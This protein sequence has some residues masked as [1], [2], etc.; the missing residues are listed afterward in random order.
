[1]TN[2]TSNRVVS[3][4]CG[5]CHNS[6]LMNVEVRD[7]RVIRASGVLGDPRTGG[8]LCAKGL[9]APQIAH[10]PRRILH[11]H[12]RS[13][14]RGS[15]KFEQVSWDTALSELAEKMLAAKASDGPQSVAF[16]RG[17]AAGWGF[18]YDMI[19]RLAHAFG[20]EVG[21]GASE[22]FVPRAV[23]EVLT[24]GG[25]PLLHDYDHTDLM[26]FWGRQPA[27]SGAPSLRKI[28]DARDRG[29][30]LVVVDPVRFH[31]AARA[32]Q[33][34]QV[35]P[36]TDLAMMLAMLYEIIEKGL[37]NQK[38]VDNYTNDPGLV[39]LRAH[40]H[41]KNRLGTA[42]TPEWAEGI[43]SVEAATIRTLANEYASTRKA[44]IIPGHGLEGR[45]NVT[46]TSR[47]LAILRVVTGHIDAEGS[48]VLTLP[49]PPR[50]PG[51]FLE[52]RVV[53]DFHR[54]DPVFLFAVPPYTPQGVTFPFLFMGQ[55]LLPTPD[56]LRQMNEGKT[57]VAFLQGGNP[58][59]MLPQPEVTRKTLEKVGY[60]AVVDPYLSETAMFADLV[61]PAAT[62]LER[63]GPEWFKYDYWLSSIT[64]RQQTVTVGEAWPDSKIIIQLGRKLGFTDAFPTEDVVWYIDELLKPSGI[65]YEKLCKQPTGIGVAPVVYQKYRQSGFML[66]GGK[67]QIRSDMLAG[68]GFDALPV[69][70]DSVESIRTTPEIAK[71]YPYTVFTGRAGPM[72]VHCQ[73]RTVPWLREIRPEP[74]VMIN[75]KKAAE[76]GIGERD[77]TIVESPRGGIRI[78]AE[79]NRAIRPEWLYVPGGWNEAN[80]NELGIDKAVDPVSSQANYMTCLGRIRK[81]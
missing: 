72:F 81:A 70:E 78:K 74:R 49:G 6:C 57:R 54:T 7:N 65:T 9:A 56:V 76:L 35:E 29:A 18:P 75:P 33:F 58:M 71:D 40:L 77:W 17:Q 61:L 20:T 19:Q 53:K 4:V 42:F 36:G 27:F 48:D 13:G 34:I 15:G 60:L 37:W 31:L 64:L 69:W 5:G 59:V 1:M 2:G 47:A 12:R 66:P 45:I 50:N 25:M 39:Q 38:F 62:Y 3:T 28:F 8:A 73:R 55:G 79:L 26:I 51:F 23:A 10:D 11:P 14:P 30:R 41:G 43:C 44:C 67:A 52:E 21:M 46:H 80:Y 63:T 24:Y 68:A 16:L 22:C 32:D